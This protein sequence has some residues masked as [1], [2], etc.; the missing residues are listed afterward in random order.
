M[1][2]NTLSTKL[3]PRHY[4]I[5][6]LAVLAACTEPANPPPPNHAESAG[7]VKQP[8][9]TP[10]ERILG[11]ANWAGVY[12]VTTRSSGVWNH[13]T[14]KF[15]WSDRLTY[16]APM[17]VTMVPFL[18]MG[19]GSVAEG[20]YSLN[21]S[22]TSTINDQITEANKGS[23]SRNSSPFSTD[24]VIFPSDTTFQFRAFISHWT[25]LECP[26]VA[27]LLDQ[28]YPSSVSGPVFPSLPPSFFT[29]PL[30]TENEPLHLKARM[31]FITIGNT[32]V[33][34]VPPNPAWGEMPI[35]WEIEWD[36][37]P[38]ETDAELILSAEGYENWLPLGPTDVPPVSL[39]PSQLPEP[40]STIK[41]TAALIP[42]VP[43]FADRAESIEFEL[44]SSNLKGISMNKP[45]DAEDTSPQD[46]QFE[47]APN[48]ALNLEFVDKNRVKTPQ[49]SYNHAFAELSAFDFGAHGTVKA[50]AHLP[51]GKVLLSK[52]VMSD[53][54]T[55][56]NVDSPLNIPKRDSQSQI[57]DSW[58]QSKEAMALADN[59]D[60]DKLPNGL[61]EEEHS[62]DGLTLFEEYRGFHLKGTH[63][64]T[65]PKEV[66]YFLNNNYGPSAD[67]GINFFASLT[68][69]KVHKLD[70]G[71]FGGG[72]PPTRVLN[73]NSQES[74]HIV[75]QHIV[76]MNR[77]SSPTETSSITVGG[78]STP[79]MI[80]SIELITI[81]DAVERT[82][83]IAHELAHSVNVP[84]HGD[85]G[86]FKA[87][88]ERVGSDLYEIPSDTP[89][90]P[91][92]MPSVKIQ[93]VRVEES[94]QSGFPPATIPE[95]IVGVKCTQSEF[96]SLGGEESCIMR[97]R[98]NAVIRSD[99]PLVRYVMS[100]PELP[101]T[102]LCTSTNGSSFNQDTGVIY[103]D[104]Q[105]G[106]AIR[107]TR[108]GQADQANKRG[109][110]AH[111]ICVSD[112][113][114]HKPA[115][116]ATENPSCTPVRDLSSLMS[117]PIQDAPR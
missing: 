106:Q 57:A 53:G 81:N 1:E 47:E 66:D 73:V 7:I 84:H 3:H 96:N 18:N 48:T 90:F 64:R 27:T 49:G 63:T 30:P 41:I 112:F 95:V 54:Q 111:R 26:A 78:P 19:L 34:S 68:H 88:W 44:V 29:F 25:M 4:L 14:G 21:S 31:H 11:V 45:L 115:Y 6:G 98:A 32:V 50:I 75:D 94:N 70:S 85:L 15:T 109:D 74:T 52:L 89:G 79:W 20:F 105:Y 108:H 35:E 17:R 13:D 51:S 113:Y 39:N 59:S 77:K 2:T 56:F 80:Q 117:N 102:T 16:R 43:T 61:G 86:L 46:L 37:W 92:S 107:T 23:C 76:I 22:Y 71:E 36:L 40:G 62:G 110:C 101:G 58:K 83:H 93:E 42:L 100:R 103:N 69:I 55:Q 8:L 10:K 116:G 38:E 9:V 91:Q 72:T 12:R 87:R 82:S 5:M 28:T 65:S 97:R 24:R 104:P 67:S 99:A 33:Q 60:L 114:K